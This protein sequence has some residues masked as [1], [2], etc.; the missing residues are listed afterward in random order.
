LRRKRSGTQKKKQ[1]SG[2]CSFHGFFR[3]MLYSR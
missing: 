1:K 3:S 2:D